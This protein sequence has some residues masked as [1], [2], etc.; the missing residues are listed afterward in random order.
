MAVL[1]LKRVSLLAGFLLAACSANANMRANAADGV[2]AEGNVSAATET[3]TAPPPPP[4]PAAS[5]AAPKPTSPECPIACSYAEGAHFKAV[6]GAEA[7]ALETAFAPAFARF[8]EC[9]KPANGGLAARPTVTLNV[10]FDAEGHVADVGLD[11]H[12]ASSDRGAC[13]SAVPLTRPEITMPGAT[14]VRCAE[15]CEHSDL[16][17]AKRAPKSGHRRK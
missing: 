7:D 10:R 12:G 16:T 2:S 3:E 8:A 17:N 15:R 11:P 5:T 6:A 9:A 4:A 13:F 1:P 14:T